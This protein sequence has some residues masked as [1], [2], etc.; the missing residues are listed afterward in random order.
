MCDYKSLLSLHL[1]HMEP[2]V[3]NIFN[4]LAPFANEFANLFTIS[5]IIDLYPHKPTTY[6]DLFKIYSFD[7]LALTGIISNALETSKNYNYILGLIK[8]ILYLIFAF[9][10]PNLF[11]HDVLYSKYFTN[12]KFI[13]GLI[14]IYL[15]ELTINVLFCLFKK[16]LYEDTENNHNKDQ[17]YQKHQ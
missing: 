11:M 4:L 3:Y 6:I 5:N 12:Y 1:N 10:L 7:M 2:T 8:G 9:A 17:K 15:L 14:I 13:V 16:Y